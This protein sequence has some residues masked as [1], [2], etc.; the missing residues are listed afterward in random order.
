MPLTPPIVA[1]LTFASVEPM[2]RER[3]PIVAPE[4]TDHNASTPASP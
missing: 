1:D 3:I 2:L 4:W